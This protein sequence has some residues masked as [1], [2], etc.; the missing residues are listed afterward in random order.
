M[1]GR[2]KATD[3]LMIQL[4]KPFI[5]MPEIC[6]L[7][8][9]LSA[10]LAGCHFQHSSQLSTYKAGSVLSASYALL[11]CTSFFIQPTFIFLSLTSSVPF[12]FAKL[13]G[14]MNK[15]ISY[16]PGLTLGYMV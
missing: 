1:G 12:C 5:I 9:Q 4:Q 11:F 14:L 8:S 16:T 13:L 6:R 7:I 10:T 2:V 3:G 15:K